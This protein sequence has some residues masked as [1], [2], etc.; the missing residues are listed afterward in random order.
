MSLESA[1]DEE[2]RAVM[3]ILEGRN[4]QRSSPMASS[5]AYGQNGRN[6]SPVAPVRSML[7]IGPAAP[8]HGSI[9]GGGVGVTP[10]PLRSAPLIS[11][12]R[13][14]LD[15]LIPP[16]ARTTRSTTTSPTE[17]KLPTSGLHRAQSDASS[18]PM[19]GRFRTV[20]D[21]DKNLQSK[22]QF[23]MTSTVSGAALPKRVS[24]G[25]K[26]NKAGRSAMASIV[27]D[28]VLDSIPP[29]DSG[30]HNS[31]ASILGG[32]SRSPS[33]RLNKRSQSPS[34][35]MLNTNSF[36]PMSV[37]GTFVTD[38]GKVIDMNSAYRRLSDAALL[39]SGGNLSLLPK[40]NSA[41][42][43]RAGSGEVLSPAGE[44]RLQK[45]Y[46]EHEHGEG[47][48]ES[49]DEEHSSDDD[50]WS[51]QNPRGRRRGRRKKSSSGDADDDSD[52]GMK[53]GPVGMGRS[54]TPRMVRT[55][56]GAAEEE[57]KLCGSWYVISKTTTNLTLGRSQYCI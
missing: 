53:E 34:A 8:R 37:P 41:A 1:L 10:S 18:H 11:G 4:T 32:H 46:Y 50:A 49:S 21:K 30:R 54:G 7:D 13:S 17:V 16:A 12:K 6:S 20:N 48:I 47:A 55:L 22:Y 27:Q 25:G 14:M 28:Q 3:D 42:R 45:D 9:A 35:G 15:P 36:N 52:E 26:K 23:D 44:P 33:S 19:E 38:S 5:S 2:R 39:N 43:A 31:T 57:R 40:R 29:R 51:T 24:L 56:M